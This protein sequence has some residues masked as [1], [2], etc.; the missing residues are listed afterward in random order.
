M[1][2][3]SQNLTLTLIIFIVNKY[4]T[5]GTRGKLLSTQTARYENPIQKVMI[6]ELGVESILALSKIPAIYRSTRRSSNQKYLYYLFILQS[7]M[8][9]IVY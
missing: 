7:P 5:D 3:F 6:F 1:L 4:Y 2:H 8:F 9:I